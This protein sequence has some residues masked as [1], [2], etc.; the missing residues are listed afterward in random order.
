[1]VGMK[2]R[3][4]NLMHTRI[5][6][7]I[8]EQRMA[9]CTPGHPSRRRCVRWRKSGLIKGADVNRTAV[10]RDASTH[11]L[12]NGADGIA[13]LHDESKYTLKTM[14]GDFSGLHLVCFMYTGMKQINPGM[15]TG[16]DLS[17][18]CEQARKMLDG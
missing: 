1:M 16:I 5:G 15:D 11:S 9:A 12:H 2:S 10:L 13:C 7:I 8:R 6:F 17:M 18:E 14:P 4:I 3:M